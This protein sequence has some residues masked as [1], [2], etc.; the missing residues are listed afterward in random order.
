VSDEER[1]FLRRW[2]DRKLLRVEAP[3]ADEAAS[4]SAPSGAV[5]SEAA[6][7][8]PDLPPIE[9]LTA[10]SDYTQ[11][12]LP[13]VPEALRLASLRRAWVTD[14]AIAGHKSMADYDWDFNA[15]GYGAL[16]PSDDV[17]KLA[18]AILNPP[19][20]V[21]RPEE[22]P[23]IAAAEPAPAPV[24]V[25]LV[26]APEAAANVCDAVQQEPEVQAAPR[27]HGSALPD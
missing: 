1:S 22:E 11:F 6:P 21:E 26:P 10:D 3:K 25:A 23:A 16:R 17:R 13:G 20:P 19:P 4:A 7:P 18:D 15:P 27:R 2:S 12:L 5:D 14:P 9:S 8:L 24:E